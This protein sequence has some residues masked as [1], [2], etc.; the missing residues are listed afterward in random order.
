VSGKKEQDT[1]AR[2]SSRIITEVVSIVH[3]RQKITEERFEQLVEKAVT[4][5]PEHIRKRMDNVAVVVEK[6][7]SAY[8]L[9]QV[10]MKMGSLLLGLY[11]GVPKT[12]WNRSFGMRLPDKITIFQEP[13]ERLAS[14][15]ERVL[16]LVRIVVW[17]EVAHHF[18]LNER[19]V[20]KLEEKWKRR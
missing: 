5:L 8:E 19:E 15:A 13:I 3:M 16:E 2:K 17:H 7:P 1:S 20:R 6:K 18:G 14:S 11:Q 4:S 12:A 10:G 9:K